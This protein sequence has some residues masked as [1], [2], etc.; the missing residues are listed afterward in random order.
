MPKR[1]AV[2]ISGAGRSLRNLLLQQHRYDYEICA[3]I[4][5]SDKAKGNTIA[6]EHNLPLFIGTFN[7]SSQDDSSIPLQEFLGKNDIQLIALAGFLKP[8][9]ILD[10]YSKQIVNIHPALLPQ[11]G[12]RGMFGMNVHRSV[13][14]NSEEWSGATIHFVTE[15][16]DEGKIISQIRIR[17]N[18]IN[19]PEELADRVFAAECKLYPMTLDLLSKGKSPEDVLIINGE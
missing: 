17:T 18:G 13:L 16:Y 19:N 7:S 12:G 10:S 9:P 4:S 3:I 6:H 1:I 5:S 8:F 14:Q 15:V 2:A 11:Y